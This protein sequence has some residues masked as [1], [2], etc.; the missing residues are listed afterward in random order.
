MAVHTIT[1]KNINALAG[2][3]YPEA[4]RVSEMLRAVI[5]RVEARIIGWQRYWSTVS[6]LRQLSDRRLAD[7]GIGRGDIRAVARAAAMPG[8]F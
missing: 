4:W 3:E 5:T 2:N 6:Q 7:I 1:A 8:A